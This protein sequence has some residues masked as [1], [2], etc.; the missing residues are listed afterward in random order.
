VRGRAERDVAS[1][2]AVSVIRHDRVVTDGWAA[3]S[4]RFVPG[5]R[6]KSARDRVRDALVP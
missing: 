5:D 1:S 6:A 4:Y 3:A 2:L